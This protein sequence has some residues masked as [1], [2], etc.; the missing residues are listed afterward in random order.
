MIEQLNG[1][2]EPAPKGALL[3]KLFLL[4]EKNLYKSFSMTS[5]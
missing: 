5:L 1:K 4:L 3:A 2:N